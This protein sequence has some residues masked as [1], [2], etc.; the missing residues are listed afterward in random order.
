MRLLATILIFFM[1][2]TSCL[3]GHNSENPIIDEVEK[4]VPVGDEIDINLIIDCDS[5]DSFF[6]REKIKS[7][8]FKNTTLISNDSIS[9]KQGSVSKLKM[10]RLLG[11]DCVSIKIDMTSYDDR[12]YLTAKDLSDFSI[13]SYDVIY[14]FS[15]KSQTATVNAKS[16]TVIAYYLGYNKIVREHE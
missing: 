2:M 8:I 6:K 4:I 10:R 14:R 5:T 15:S 11:G 3:I 9:L 12:V 13:T 16:I 1:T 7:V